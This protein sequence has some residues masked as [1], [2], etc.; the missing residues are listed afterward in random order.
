[1]LKNKNQS[2]G[3]LSD[4]RLKE[5]IQDSRSYLE[6]IC[7]IKV[8][9]F[10][11][12]DTGPDKPQLGVLAQDVQKIFPKLV[13][14]DPETGNLSVKYSVFNTML[15]QCVQEL[16]ANMEAQQAQIDDLKAVVETLL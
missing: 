10:N 8:K 12:K 11:F 7:K 3:A 15:I 6:D 16:S 4:E 2:Y 9:K 14:E 13:T 5:N 1:M